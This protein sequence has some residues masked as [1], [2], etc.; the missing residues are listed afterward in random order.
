M[1]LENKKWIP[2]FCSGSDL[3][4]DALFVAQSAPIMED[5]NPTRPTL[6]PTKRPTVV[7]DEVTNRPT[8][9]TD[10]ANN[11]PT[12]NTDDNNIRPTAA[13]TIEDEP[14]IPTPSK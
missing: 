6:S 12:V 11:R 2:R 9:I 3:K 5:P 10:N 7:T 1:S 4:K 13:T 8:A 14:E